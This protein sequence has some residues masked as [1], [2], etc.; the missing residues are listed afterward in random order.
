MIKTSLKKSFVCGI[1]LLFVGMSLMPIAGSL[2]VEK[3]S[4][5]IGSVKELHNLPKIGTRGINV[6]LNGTMGNNGWYVGPVS[7]EITTDNGTEIGPILYRIN[8]GGWQTYTVPFVFNNDGIYFFELKIYDQY[9]NEW[10]FSFDF[11]IDMTPP[12]EFCQ[13]IRRFNKIIYTA[14]PVDNV[15]GVDRVEF[16]FNEALQYIAYAPGPYQWTLSP[17]PHVNGTVKAVAYDMAGNWA[18]TPT[19]SLSQ[20]NKQLNTQQ[21]NQHDFQRSLVRQQMNQFFQNLIFGHITTN[22][23]QINKLTFF[24]NK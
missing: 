1:V 13:G 15:S 11:K 21:N 17:I 24:N 6:T 19:H 9:G 4:L 7:F 18:W 2:S 3:H 23:I 12:L 10:Y 20:S 16:Y 14:Y 8:Y 22:Y 5:V